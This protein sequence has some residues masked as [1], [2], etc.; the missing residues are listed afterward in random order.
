MA[1][2]VNTFSKNLKA[3]VNNLCPLSNTT[4]HYPV[5]A[6]KINV[7]EIL[8]QFLVLL[9]NFNPNHLSLE[10]HSGEF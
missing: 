9:L 2:V 7:L 1:A 6:E 5:P 8:L 10:R 3:A 4:G